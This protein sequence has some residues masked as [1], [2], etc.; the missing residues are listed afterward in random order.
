MRMLFSGPT[1]VA[2]VWILVW[3]CPKDPCIK[4][5]VSKSCV[6]SA[7]RLETFRDEAFE[8]DWTGLA[9]WSGAL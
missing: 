6:S 9:S 3:L 2:M 1:L 4:D 7:K 5:L 8:S